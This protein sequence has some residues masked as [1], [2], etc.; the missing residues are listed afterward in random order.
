MNNDRRDA[1]TK[2]IERISEM[3]AMA[4]SIREE[5]ETIR[6]EEQEYFDNMPEGLANSERGEKAENA[7]D[8]LNQV[9]D[10]LESLGEN[11]FAHCL[12]EAM[13]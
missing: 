2:I 4:A 7:I 5:V 1:I 11:D 3:Q 13:T 10:D 12:T 9:I 8:Q 6:D